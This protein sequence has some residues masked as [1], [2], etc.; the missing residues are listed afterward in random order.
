M[1]NEL[2]TIEERD[3][4]EVQKT[5]EQ[6][7]KRSG[8]LRPAYKAMNETLSLSTDKRFSAQVDPKGNAWAPLK[9]AT[10]K[11]KKN[12]L[13]LTEDT[14][15][16]DGIHGEVESDGLL[17][18][19]DSPYGAIHQ[20]GGEIKQEGMVLHLKGSGRNTRFAKAA[21]ATHG[22]K[23]NRTIKMPARPFLGVSE[24]DEKDLLQDVEAYLS[25]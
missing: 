12:P 6:L 8:D 5:L 13:I 15:L 22:M 16:R 14:K 24:Q 4:P 17:F 25:S 10:K 9:S 19:S 21:D 1:A 23:V 3:L 7:Y 18:G 2:V 20:L 11:R